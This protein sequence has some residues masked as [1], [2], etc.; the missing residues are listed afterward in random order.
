[1]DAVSLFAIL[2]FVAAWI[3]HARSDRDEP[4]AR[5]FFAALMILAAAIG[6]LGLLLRL[7]VGR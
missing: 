2:T 1:M 3:G 7:L 4:L 5:L 6:G